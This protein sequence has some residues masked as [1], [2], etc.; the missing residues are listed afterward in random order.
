[1]SGDSNFFLTPTSGNKGPTNQSS[2][3]Y[4]FFDII[5]NYSDG[6]G[7]YIIVQPSD[8]TRSLQLSKVQ[9]SSTDPSLFSIEY[10][11]SRGRVSNFDTSRSAQGMS[12]V[13]KGRG[14]M[15]DVASM[16]SEYLG[17][18]APESVMVKE[19]KPDAPV[20]TVTLGGAGQ[21]AVETTPTWDKSPL[22]RMGW[23]TRRDGGALVTD[24]GAGGN[25][26]NDCVIEVTPLNNE[27]LGLAGWGTYMFPPRGRIHLENG[28]SAEYYGLDANKF[29]LFG[30][31]F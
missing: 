1:M 12:L 25:N 3:L 22:S 15:D 4:E 7:Q 9:T 29:Y 8:R 27:S 26:V 10:L 5:D 13:L 30:S 19:T 17:E 24:V 31:I 23:T 11:V 21:G 2:N 16:K 18:G 6:N 28:A 14:L 20:V